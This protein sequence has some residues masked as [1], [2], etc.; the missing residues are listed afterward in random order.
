MPAKKTP[1][2]DGDA[3]T[4]EPIYIPDVVGSAS[5]SPNSYGNH[6][7]V[8]L[9]DLPV[10]YLIDKSNW[11]DFKRALNECAMTWNFP[12]WMTTIV[13]KGKEWTEMAQKG[14]DLSQYFPAAKK[15]AAGD[16]VSSTVSDL[17]Q[18]LVGMLNL[19]SNV[20]EYRDC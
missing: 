5:G 14:T 15:K 9:A 4:E 10:V 17:S 13:Y 2:P 11:V 6:S 20:H 8:P 12:A 1:S 7:D 18:K 3:K 16:G 19:P